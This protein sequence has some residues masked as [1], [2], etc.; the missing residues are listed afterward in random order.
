VTPELQAQIDAAVTAI[1][2]AHGFAPQEQEPSEPKGVAFTWLSDGPYQRLCLVVRVLQP[3]ASL[4][5]QVVFRSTH[6][7]KMPRNIQ[8]AKKEDYQ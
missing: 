3:E 6:P 8:K 7:P 5:N 4:T 1:L 2:T